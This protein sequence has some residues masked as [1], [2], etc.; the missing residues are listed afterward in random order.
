M[1]I[2]LVFVIEWKVLVSR[3]IVPRGSSLSLAHSFKCK[4]ERSFLLCLPPPNTLSE[5]A[6]AAAAAR[7]FMDLFRSLHVSVYWRFPY[8]GG[9]GRKDRGREEG[10]LISISISSLC[11]L[12]R[13]VVLNQT[14]SGEMA[15]LPVHSVFLYHG[16]FVFDR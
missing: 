7:T 15:R 11:P 10:E 5:P 14:F 8:G 12:R 4:S 1:D 3:I 16:S 6:A 2:Q 9:G 13:H